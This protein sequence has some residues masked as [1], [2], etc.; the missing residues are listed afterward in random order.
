MKRFNL[1][2]ML[3]LF[4]LI[5]S[6]GSDDS[7]SSDE[8]LVGTWNLLTLDYSGVSS[9]TGSGISSSSEFA[10]EA[11]DISTT[12][13]FN[14][15]NT[16]VASGSY[17]ITLVTEI[18]GTAFEQEVVFTDFLGT[19]TWERDGD[20]VRTQADGQPEAA[21]LMIIELDGSSLIFDFETSQTTEMQGFITSFSVDGRY[22]FDR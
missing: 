16:Y 5:C 11:S 13:T 6:C 12:L 1:L 4:G 8:G 9:V 3:G 17:T 7:S 2:F 18:M 15:D 10:G 22:T 14:D 19:G 21:P 20:I